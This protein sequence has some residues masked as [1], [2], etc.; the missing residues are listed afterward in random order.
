MTE[1]TVER[2]VVGVTVVIVLAFCNHRLRTL[3]KGRKGSAQRDLWDSK[4]E[5]R[6]VKKRNRRTLDEADVYYIDAEAKGIDL[7]MFYRLVGWVKRKGQVYNVCTR[8]EREVKDDPKSY[9]LTLRFV[10]PETGKPL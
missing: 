7:Y 5:I 8:F 3:V 2:I 6:Q 4:Q 1:D 9:H 10:D